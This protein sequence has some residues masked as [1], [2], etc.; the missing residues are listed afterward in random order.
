MQ[1]QNNDA[2]Q[3]IRDQAKLSIT[4]GFPQKLLS[5]VQP[6]IDM[7]P[8]FHRTLLS[9]NA[10]RSTTG[11]STIYTAPAKK[12][13]YI[14]GAQISASAD[15]TSDCTEFYIAVQ[16]GGVAAVRIL[17]LMKLTTTAFS[18]SLSVSFPFPIE[19]DEGTNITLNQ[20]FTVGTNTCRCIAYIY[21]VDK[22]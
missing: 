6:V 4:E 13:V 8:R 18:D 21:E 2:T 9:K 10:S 1:I 12:R 3:I 22:F 19:I 14:C 20:S 15:A 5:N 7:T 17:S 16:Q 11:S